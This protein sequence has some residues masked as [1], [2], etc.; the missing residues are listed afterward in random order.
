MNK[1]NVFAITFMCISVILAIISHFVL[2]DN[3]VVQIS[4]GKS[5]ASTLPKLGAIALPTAIGVMFGIFS[6]VLKE[7][8][9]SSLKCLFA[10]GVGVIMFLVMLVVNCIM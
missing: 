4:I 10:S 7:D 1:R 9:K 5:E 2:P 3:V 8:R 6:L